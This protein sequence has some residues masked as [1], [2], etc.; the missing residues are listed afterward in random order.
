MESA[1]SRKNSHRPA[2]WVPALPSRLMNASSSK[3][4]SL[5]TDTAAA[6]VPTVA[7]VWKVR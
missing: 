1:A 6:R 4:I 5:P 3:S 7:V 2:A